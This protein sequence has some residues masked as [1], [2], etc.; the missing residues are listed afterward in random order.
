MSANVST[1]D[2]GRSRLYDLASR[3]VAPVLWLALLGYQWAFA[4]MVLDDVSQIVAQRFHFD[5]RTEPA[6]I[7]GL[8][9]DAYAAI[10]LFTWSL[11]L[12]ACPRAMTAIF[13][14]R[15]NRLL[16]QRR[17]ARCVLLVAF[18]GLAVQGVWVAAIVQMHGAGENM[19][20]YVFR[21]AFTRIETHL[22][23]HWQLVALLPLATWI[24]M[25]AFRRESVR[26]PYHWIAACWAGLVFVEMSIAFGLGQAR[27]LSDHGFGYEE[28]MSTFARFAAIAVVAV[29][30]VFEYRQ[31]WQSK[32]AEF[33]TRCSRES[34]PANPQSPA[35]S[36]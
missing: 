6:P 24:C 3:F 8:L 32:L 36:P 22:P 34:L 31:L 2:R 19:A 4:S 21:R 18:I 15:D 23:W 33:S 1:I 35:P 14:A 12:A 13:S 25:L 29:A 9:C 16:A 17:L 5:T 11:W 30:L 7:W 20:D 10:N 28:R 26:N 27:F